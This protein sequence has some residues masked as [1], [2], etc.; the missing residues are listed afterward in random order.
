MPTAPHSTCR[1]PAHT[2]YVWHIIRKHVQTKLQRQ[3]VNQ[4]KHSGRAASESTA[5]S[6]IRILG[7]TF[8]KRGKKSIPMQYRTCVHMS[9]MRK[10]QARQGCTVHLTAYILCSACCPWHLRRPHRHRSH[11]C[12]TSPL[13]KNN[14]TYQ[15]RGYGVGCQREEG[16][17]RGSVP[18]Y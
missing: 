11:S 3:E 13:V 10:Q 1:R 14:Q 6:A 7:H 17:R 2:W 15:L 8:E 9:G 5:G 12:R 4:R 16:V 18:T